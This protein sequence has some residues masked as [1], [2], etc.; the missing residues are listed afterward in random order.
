MAGH[1]PGS[2]LQGGGHGG[3]PGAPMG[4]NPI[5]PVNPPNVANYQ[6]VKQSLMLLSNVPEFWNNQTYRFDQWIL[7]FGGAIAYAGLN[8][9]QKLLMLSQKMRGSA[10]DVLSQIRMTTADYNVVRDRLHQRFPAEETQ[11]YFVSEFQSARRRPGE[12]VSDFGY[13]L[14]SLFERGYPPDI[15]LANNAN[16]LGI[17]LTV[18][19]SQFLA[20]LEPELSFKLKYTPNLN[21]YD[22]LVAEAQEQDARLRERRRLLEKREFV[23]AVG[24]GAGVSAALAAI[25]DNLS[26]LHV[27]QA[28]PAKDSLSEVVAVMA[29]EITKLKQERN[30]PVAPCSTQ[31][32]LN[33]SLI[34]AI[35]KFTE[36]QQ[37][38]PRA[39]SK[40][41]GNSRNNYKGRRNDKQRRFSG[42]NANDQCNFCG[43]FG[44]T[45]DRC[46]IKK[47]INSPNNSPLTCG[48]CNQTGHYSLICPSRT[49]SNI[50]GQR[51]SQGNE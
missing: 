2:I 40:P 43:R 25:S 29:E 49:R 33:E 12:S 30:Q 42:N 31:E 27:Q 22:D 20:G 47:R 7:L 10:V 28:V 51:Q 5:V 38:Q 26:K 37:E 46:F 3:N 14:R 41:H 32:N 24:E 15:Q 45:L 44:H 6:A 39:P 34:A 8:D 18:L 13:R 11:A 19:S 17:R 21:T 35:T 1:Y 23:S 36:S 48:T 16:E 50:P 4:I 9:D